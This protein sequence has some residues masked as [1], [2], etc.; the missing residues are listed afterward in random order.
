M[1]RSTADRTNS[2]GIARYFSFQNWLL[3]ENIYKDWDWEEGKEGG[4][5]T[6][7][8]PHLD[9]PIVSTRDN[10]GQRGMKGC[11]IHSP[12]VTLEDIFHNSISTAEQISVHLLQSMCAVIRRDSYSYSAT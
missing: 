6:V 5:G 3:V 11:P 8:S 10:E 1:S 2:A 12:V 9:L 4:G 7:H